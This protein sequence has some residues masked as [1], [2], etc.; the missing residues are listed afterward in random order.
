LVGKEYILIAELEKKQGRK[1]FVNC[2]IINLENEVCLEGKLLF[3]GVDWGKNYSSS[4]FKK[5]GDP[6][7]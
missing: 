2:K 7:F 5:L 3:L 6:E 1:I 4:L